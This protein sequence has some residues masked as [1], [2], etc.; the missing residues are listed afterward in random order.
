[1][2]EIEAALHSL[3]V[4]KS[5]K[6]VLFTSSTPQSFCDGVDYSSLVQPTGEKRRIAA[7]ELAKK[8]K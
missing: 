2:K 8:L 4:E 3:E 7:L 6:L 1:M 5:C